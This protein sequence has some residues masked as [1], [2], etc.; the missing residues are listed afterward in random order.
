MDREPDTTAKRLIIHCGV[1]KTGSTSL[2]HFLG[3]NRDALAAHV[4]A[5]TPAKG[6][7]TRDL[8]NAA[9]RFSLRPTD[10]RLL[11]LRECAGLVRDAILE[12]GAETVLISHENLL[13][14]MLGNSGT[15]TLYPR[16]ERIV[17]VLNRVFAP[18]VPEYV[19]YTR[20]LPQWKRSVH[21]QAIRSDRY[22]GTLVDFL[23]K[24]E[25]C[26]SWAQTE[27]RLAKLVGAARSTLF[28]VED[29][30]DEARPG[31]QLLRY[32]GVSEAEIA[33]LHPVRGRS[34]TR[35]NAG[36]LEFQRLVNQLGLE[37][38]ARRAIGELIAGNQ[39]LFVS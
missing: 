21:A 26:G 29:E 19:V 25:A 22:S 36:G 20:D 13:G 17:E 27:R 30:P 2:H 8:G 5:L 28:R 32:A 35:I 24:T 15:V 23:S 1:Q 16:L 34:K 6:S 18:L 9:M 4:L 3:R 14:A 37:R 7:A 31:Q 11:R 10:E 39:R 12:Q 33:A 38:P